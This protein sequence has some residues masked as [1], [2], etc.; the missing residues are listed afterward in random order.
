MK[1]GH[2]SSFERHAGAEGRAGSPGYLDGRRGLCRPCHGDPGCY[3]PRRM[4]SLQSS[5]RSLWRG[6]RP[7]QEGECQGV[8]RDGEGEQAGLS[9]VDTALWAMVSMAEDG[10]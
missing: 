2:C 10:Q 1:E 5:R 7:D 4:G 6:V 9:G 8:G 3:E